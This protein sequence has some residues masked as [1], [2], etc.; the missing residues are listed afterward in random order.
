MA[1]SRPDGAYRVE[2]NGHTVARY[3]VTGGRIVWAL[4][5]PGAILPATMPPAFTLADL[6][7]RADMQTVRLPEAA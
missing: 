1:A 2:H 6:I 5:T 3:I 4:I 7:D